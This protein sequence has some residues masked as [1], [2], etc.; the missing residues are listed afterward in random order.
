MPGLWLWSV[1][2]PGHHCQPGMLGQD[3]MDTTLAS[4]KA[5]LQNQPKPAWPQKVGVVPCAGTA[6]SSHSKTRQMFSLWYLCLQKRTWKSS[7]EWSCVQPLPHLSVCLWEPLCAL[8]SPGVLLLL[9][10]LGIMKDD[11][12]SNSKS[13]SCG[14]SH[15]NYPGNRI[16]LPKF[17]IYVT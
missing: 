13:F 1:S 5:W 6:H 15:E 16:H 9:P 2:I 10:F 3:L 11:G 8:G 4:C 14:I 7:D 12:I 17:G